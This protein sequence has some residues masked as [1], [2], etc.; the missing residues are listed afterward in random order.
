MTT[1]RLTPSPH[2]WGGVIDSPAVRAAQYALQRSDA[3]RG[4]RAAGGSG[5]NLSE[6][7]RALVAGQMADDNGR[8]LLAW[9]SIPDPGF[10]APGYGGYVVSRY[11]VFIRSRGTQGTLTE[12][13]RAA[14]EGGVTLTVT[15]GQPRPDDATA[16]VVPQWMAGDYPRGFRLGYDMGLWLAERHLN[17]LSYLPQSPANDSNWVLGQDT[18]AAREWMTGERYPA[19]SVVLL[20]RIPY[21]AGA[22]VPAGDVAAE[23][24]R[25]VPGGDYDLGGQAGRRAWATAQP[26]APAWE[27]GEYA[28]LDEASI[29]GVDYVAQTRIND[30]RILPWSPLNGRGWGTSGE[31]ITLAEVGDT[32]FWEP[33]TAA[34]G[35]TVYSSGTRVIVPLDLA[36]FVDSD[37]DI[38]DPD[39][40]A[41][42]QGQDRIAVSWRLQ[43]NNPGG[44]H[45]TE[46]QFA[47]RDIELVPG[48]TWTYAGTTAEY[49]FTM[50]AVR[51]RI[52][53]V[54][55]ALTTTITCERDFIT[56][57]WYRM[58]RRFLGAQITPDAFAP[59]G[60]FLPKWLDPS[61]IFPNGLDEGRQFGSGDADWYRHFG[62][63][64]WAGGDPPRIQRP[65]RTSSDIA[66]VTHAIVTA[67]RNIVAG[68]DGVPSD[69]FYN[70]QR[71]AAYGRT[72]PNTDSAQIYHIGGWG[73]R[74]WRTK[75]P[76]W[77][78]DDYLYQDRVVHQGATYE[79]AYHLYPPIYDPESP[80]NNAD[81]S[82]DV[83][84]WVPD[85]A[86]APGA[87]VVVAAD[88][89]AQLAAD[90]T[91]HRVGD[92]TA[93]IP[94]LLA[95]RMANF[96]GADHD[97]GGVPGLRAWRY[98]GRLLVF[99]FDP[100]SPFARLRMDIT[101]VKTD[102]TAVDDVYLLELD[103]WVRW[104]FPLMDTRVSHA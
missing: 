25:N 71:N 28:Q 13:V 40:G 34:D 19:D 27:V 79:A 67:A 52:L 33:E 87:N 49:V 18:T 61:V 97:L 5:S 72:A 8:R 3:L 32:P 68:E 23:R 58:E 56:Q 15:R 41:R 54:R 36:P 53:R 57:S 30:V 75:Y 39:Q 92:F 31:P 77:L 91:Y 47:T 35:V 62:D 37:G 45:I 55:Y 104:L 100:D 93:P 73:R 64:F 94:T 103:R 10:L 26:D 85:R 69:T 83:P 81:W 76:A 6:V 63:N 66:A 89:Y 96:P 14:A 50:E 20:N 80:L 78:P 22:I 99:E 2:T 102:G 9:L 29:S 84:M 17:A 38:V 60:P 74:L 65:Y 16:A 12:L 51:T 88:D 4:Y 101:A 48:Y 90:E 82:T 44:L 24:T 7:W 95:A 46:P 43:T 1:Q 59:G 21:F 98:L 42:R 70:R 86:Y 11:P